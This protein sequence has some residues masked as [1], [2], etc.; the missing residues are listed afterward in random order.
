[1]AGSDKDVDA[2]FVVLAA[3][4]MVAFGGIGIT[5]AVSEVTQ[6]FRTI[7]ATG[8][9]HRGRIQW[10]LEHASPAGKV[11]AATLLSE[12]DPQA[13][14]K[15]WEQLVDDTGTFQTGMGC[16][17]GTGTV[18]DYARRE[19]GQVV[20][21][22]PRTALT[23]APP[24][25][26]PKP[27]PPLA[28]SDAAKRAIKEALLGRPRVVLMSARDETH[29]VE[30]LFG[31]AVPAKR[32]WVSRETRD[33]FERGP[34]FDLYQSIVDPAYPFLATFNLTGTATV[35]STE[36]DPELAAY[37]FKHYPTITE[38]AYAAR[39]FVSALALQQPGWRKE[40]QQLTEGVGMFIPQRVGALPVIHEVRPPAADGPQSQGV[41]HKYIVPRNE[42]NA[43]AAA[44]G[45]RFVPWQSDSGRS[46]PTASVRLLRK[47]FDPARTD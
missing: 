14:R 18:S 2:A 31:V 24:R 8:A 10:L 37:Y 42:Q 20:E 15:A 12:L 19:L 26:V 35:E 28:D 17:I 5:G 6:A 11:Y 23:P 29:F 7:K 41:F 33:G 1:M 44:R 47:D 9:E 40:S 45:Q 13:G 39:R 22:P 38:S 27:G 43:L 30:S 36:L 46:D 21:Q 4:G 16:V 34:H 3:A 32:V 25:Q